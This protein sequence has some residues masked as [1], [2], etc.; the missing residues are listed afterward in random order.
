[1][2]RRKRLV[3][4]PARLRMPGVL[5]MC[6]R[7]GFD[8]SKAYVRSCKRKTSIPYQVPLA[9][10]EPLGWEAGRCIPI[11]AVSIRQR[12]AMPGESLKDLRPEAL[13]HPVLGLLGSSER[14]S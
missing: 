5:V 3:R 11:P 6:R 2:A 14:R 1:M 8:P 12:G 10:A 7:Y 13:R 9:L 4:P